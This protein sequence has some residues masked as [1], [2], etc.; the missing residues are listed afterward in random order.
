MNNGGS[1]ALRSNSYIGK[2]FK[3]K[4]IVEIIAHKKLCYFFDTS[5]MRRATA[6]GVVIEKAIQL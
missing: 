4:Y 1:L 3:L 5:E 2:T 6:I